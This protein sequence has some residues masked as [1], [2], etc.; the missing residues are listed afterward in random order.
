MYFSKSHSSFGTV[1]KTSFSY[2]K[3][4]TTAIELATGFFLSD[5]VGILFLFNHY[6]TVSSL[7]F[8]AHHIV[9][10]TAFSMVLYNKGI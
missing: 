3:E 6:G 10:I 2:N 7:Q 1:I 8:I 4:S 5:F 9:S